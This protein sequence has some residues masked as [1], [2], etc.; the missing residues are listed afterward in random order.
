MSLYCRMNNLPITTAIAILIL[1]NLWSNEWH[2]S[3]CYLSAQNMLYDEWLADIDCSD[4]ILLHCYLGESWLSNRWQSLEGRCSCVWSIQ[5][6]LV[7]LWKVN[8]KILNDICE[9]PKGPKPEAEPWLTD[10]HCFWFSCFDGGLLE[11]FIKVGI[12]TISH[13]SMRYDPQHNVPHCH[14]PHFGPLNMHCMMGQRG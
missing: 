6:G 5:L 10:K 3:S 13:S 14:I 4:I 2:I 1:C 8:G 9:Y 7:L 12:C 11:P